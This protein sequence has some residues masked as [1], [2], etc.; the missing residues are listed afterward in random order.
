MIR[1][2]DAQRT[3][4]ELTLI[5]SQGNNLVEIADKY[6]QNRKS[7]TAYNLQGA[8]NHERH[9][10]GEAIVVVLENN[11]IHSVILATSGN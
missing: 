9:Q 10:V 8:R 5:V 4:K 2:G 3:L 7:L 6:I 1:H 11:A